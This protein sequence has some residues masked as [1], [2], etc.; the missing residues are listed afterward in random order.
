[1][2]TTPVRQQLHQQIDNLPD[3]LVQIIAD[4]AAFII[5]RRGKQ[6]SYDDWEDQQWQDLA[7]G[8]FIRENDDVEYTLDDAQE[9]F[10]DESR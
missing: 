10:T 2:N 7:L 8:Q 6:V 4:F 9:V 1:M 3:D 5:T